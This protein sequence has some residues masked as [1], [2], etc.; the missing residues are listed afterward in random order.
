M[1]LTR[2]FIRRPTLVFVLVA[3]MFFA[4]IVSIVNLVQQLFPNVSQPT[5]SI[6]VQYAGASTTE[7]RD[8]IVQPIEQNLAG[9]T[10]LQ[11]ISTTVQQGRASITA[12][13]YL[14]SDVATD[15]SLTQKAVQAAEHVLPTNLSAPTVNI[16][17]PS[18]STVV[19]LSASSKTLTPSQLSLL[20]DNVIVPRLEQI[21]GVSYVTAFGDVTPAYEVQ[22]DPLKLAA[23]GLTLNDVIASVATQNQRVPGGIIYGPNRET[24]IDVRGDIQNPQS[25]A[26]EPIVT[27]SSGTT[28][29]ATSPSGSNPNALAGA[30]DPWTAQTSVLRVGDVAQV[31]AGNE[32]RRQYAQ[33]QGKP[34]MVLVVQKASDASEVTSANNV[35]AALPTIARQFP[36]VDLVVTNTLS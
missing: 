21:P 19:T 29:S 34:G 17:D 14:D 10:N 8:N 35:L 12:I 7:M 6:N 24:T 2:L 36:N 16:R 27:G 11:T 33:I 13:Y 23:D 26:S 9:T 3:L 5:I 1:N 4:G 22:G 20:V 18:E 31:G 30:V 28:S 15:L 32:T 25:V